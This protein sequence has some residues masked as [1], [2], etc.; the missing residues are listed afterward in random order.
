MND[1]QKRL[2]YTNTQTDR[3]T[4]GWTGRCTSVKRDRQIVCGWTY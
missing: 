4:D 2:R 1:E 3:E